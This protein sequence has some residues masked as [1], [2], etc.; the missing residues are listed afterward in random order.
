[1]A[2]SC[3]M[4][5]RCP[6]LWPQGQEIAMRLAVSSRITIFTCLC[7]VCRFPEDSC[8]RG[9]RHLRLDAVRRYRFGHDWSVS[10]IISCGCVKG[11]CLICSDDDADDTTQKERHET[12]WGF[13]V[14]GDVGNGN[15]GDN[16]DGA[17]NCWFCCNFEFYF[18]TLGVCVW[19][20]CILDVL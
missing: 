15:A 4:S 1:M 17:L 7:V 8:E 14:C 2:G 10:V 5:L 13:S 11:R 18:H 20:G 3:W 6:L 16:C 12:I 19:K 9:V